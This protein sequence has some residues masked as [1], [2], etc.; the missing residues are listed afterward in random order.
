MLYENIIDLIGNTPIVKLNNVGNNN[1][2]LKL[3]RQNPGGSVKDRAVYHMIDG[4]EKEGK[5]EKGDV[6]VE[7]SSGNTG[8]ALAM[9]GKIKGYEVIIVM[10]ETMSIER[11]ML[12]SA[13]GAKLILT[14]GDKG[15]S[16]AVEVANQLL[17]ENSNYK[18]LSQFDNIDNINGHYKTTGVEIYKDIPDIDI[19]ICGVGTGGTISGVAKYLKEKNPNIKIVAIE[20]KNSPK[21]SQGISGKH[22]IQGIGAGFIPKNYDDSLVDEVIVISD[23]EAFDTVKLLAEKEGILVGISS[24][25][26][27]YG[28]LLMSKLYPDKKIVTVA[29][30]GVEK[31]MSMNIF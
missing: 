18:S 30:D 16:G 21:I 23:E 22:K 26:N 2:Y 27:V 14:S 17:E 11:R 9:I 4:L 3:E 20:P 25:A 13:Y 7:A 24:G 6:L 15:M 31:Y 19:F 1:V 5:L 10:P 8:I 12:M 28:A 29:P